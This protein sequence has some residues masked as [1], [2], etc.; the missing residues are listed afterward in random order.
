MDDGD[1]PPPQRARTF[2]ESLQLSDADI[3]GLAKGNF[4]YLSRKISSGAGPDGTMETMSGHSGNAYDL[5]VVGHDGINLK[6]YYTF[7]RA[8]V[9]HFVGKGGDSE[10][11]SLEQWEREYRLFGQL[12]S[13]P[14]FSKYRTWKS[15]TVWKKGVRRDKADT[16]AKSLKGGLFMMNPILRVSLLRL[17]RL[18]VEVNE[19]KLFEYDPA[20]T[21]D[22]DEFVELQVC[23]AT[24]MALLR[25]SLLHRP[26]AFVVSAVAAVVV[27]VVVVVVV[28]IVVAA[29]TAVVA[30]ES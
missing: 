12:Y 28:A 10:F 15:F 27:V 9:T 26:V 6:D 11:T 3:E 13:I 18:C 8:G 7:S 14:F 5:C 16:A 20:K 30:L 23:A 22:L 4:L 17:R 1:A 21:Y 29:A 24:L 2:I 19:W 25:S